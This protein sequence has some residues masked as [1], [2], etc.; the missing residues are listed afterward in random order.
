MQSEGACTNATDER[1]GRVSATDGRTDAP[2]SSLRRF[3][4]CAAR[5]IATACRVCLA[6]GQPT[7]HTDTGCDALYCGTRMRLHRSLTLCRCSVAVRCSLSAAAGQPSQAL[8][9]VLAAVRHQRGETGEMRI[10][11][12]MRAVPGRQLSAMG[13]VVLCDLCLRYPLVALLQACSRF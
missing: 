1:T 12:I 9:L 8:S 10:K 6:Q 2:L 7:T 5:G 11:C 3:G 4:L 13:S